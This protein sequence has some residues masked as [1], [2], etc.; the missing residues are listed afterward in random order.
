MVRFSCIILFSFLLLLSACGGSRTISYADSKEE[1]TELLTGSFTSAAQ[2]QQDTQYAPLNLHI[3]PVW[4]ELTGNWFYAEQSK[5]TKPAQPIKQRMYRV[6]QLSS[7]RFK[8]LEYTFR[9]PQV[10]AGKWKTPTFF[11]EYPEE[12][13]RI[14]EGCGIFLNRKSFKHY[15]GE[16]FGTDCFSDLQGA[17]YMTS[18]IEI[19]NDMIKRWDRGW[20]EEETQVWGPVD[21]PYSY[22]RM[23]AATDSLVQP[24][25][26]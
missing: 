22:V 21:G 1:L 5:V 23:S 3:V 6:V 18:Q 8:I 14:K 7:E 9:N 10:F 17:D 24:K 26:N 25:S 4:K 11:D 19:W 12:I 2:A 15:E 20:N 16:T 13:V